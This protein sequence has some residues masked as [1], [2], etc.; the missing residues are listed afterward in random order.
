MYGIETRIKVNGKTGKIQGVS[1]AVQDAERKEHVWKGSDLDK[2]LSAGSILK[3]LGEENLQDKRK[4]LSSKELER[5]FRKLNDGLGPVGHFL[6]FTP[7][8]GKWVNRTTMP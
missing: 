4:V 5:S 3:T 2:T 1:F 7:Y 6:S 8:S